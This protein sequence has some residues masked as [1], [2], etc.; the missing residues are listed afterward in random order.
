[1]TFINKTIDRMLEE[2][3]CREF[4]FFAYWSPVEEPARQNRRESW[5]MPYLNIEPSFTTELFSHI[6][7]ESGVLPDQLLAGAVELAIENS[8]TRGHLCEEQYHLSVKLFSGSGGI[9]IR[10]VDSGEGFPF[11]QYIRERHRGDMSH[12]QGQGTGGIIL[13]YPVF[14]VA[15]EGK[16]NIV[17]IMALSGYSRERSE[18]ML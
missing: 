10:I 14:E 3:A 11:K 13:S 5:G 7:P 16:G 15:Y 18:R 17:N 2:I 1:M 12:V 9:V 6:P 4:P 8:L